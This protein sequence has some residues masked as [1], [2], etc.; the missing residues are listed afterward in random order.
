M[1]L[2]C[3]F[4]GHEVLEGVED[5]DLPYKLDHMKPWPCRRC[6]KDARPSWV[7]QLETDDRIEAIFLSQVVPDHKDVG[8]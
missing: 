3:F 6:G 7:I 4:M 2:V 1:S 8:R 5:F